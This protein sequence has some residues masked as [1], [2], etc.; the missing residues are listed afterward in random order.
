[1]PW[2]LISFIICIVLVTVFVGFNLDNRCNVSFGF[3]QFENVPIFL[4]LAAAFILGVLV[5]FPFTIGKKRSKNSS[6]ASKTK[7]NQVVAN[8]TSAATKEK[9]AI[10]LQR[11][12]EQNDSHNK[13]VFTTESS[14]KEDASKPEKK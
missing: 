7:E 14:A 3:V 4:S 11:K 6:M 5:V 8:K 1:M 9:N 13:V 2:K 10:L 12:H